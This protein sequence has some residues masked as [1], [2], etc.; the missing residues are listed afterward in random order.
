MRLE[1]I[2]PPKVFVNIKVENKVMLANNTSNINNSNIN[3]LLFS[4]WNDD[5]F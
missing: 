4:I 2:T 3:D 1:T 5:L